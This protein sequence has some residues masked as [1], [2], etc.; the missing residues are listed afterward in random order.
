MRKVCLCI[1]FLISFYSVALGQNRVNSI[2]VFVALCDNE[3][4]GIVPVN[5]SLGNGQNSE[6]N[7]YGVPY[8]AL[9]HIL[10][11]E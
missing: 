3:N 7:L 9:K 8:M 10:I 5:S 11:E 1:V 2:H 6:S 4:Q